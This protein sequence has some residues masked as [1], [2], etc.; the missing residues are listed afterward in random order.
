MKI[1]IAMLLT[2]C[3]VLVSSLSSC[4]NSNNNSEAK[5]TKIG[6]VLPLSGS[7]SAL[8]KDLQQ[9]ANLAL[10][11]VNNTQ[12]KQLQF[13]LED[14]GSTP[15]GATVAFNKLI[16]Q[17]ISSI[18]GPVTSSESKATFPLAQQYQVVAFSPL[19]AAQGLSEIGD[20]V[21]QGNLTVDVVIPGG[22]ELTATKLNYK[23]VAILVDSADLFSQSAFD[24]LEQTFITKGIDIVA[25]ETLQTN[26]SDFSTQLTRIKDTSPDAI[27]ISALPIEVVKILTQAKTLGIPENVTFI[28]PLAFSTEEVAQAGTAAENVITFST[29]TSSAQTTGNQAFI[30]KYRASFGTEPSRFLAQE[31]AAVHILAEAVKNAESTEAASIRDALT[32]IKDFDTILGKF[33]FDSSGRAIYDPIILVVKNGAFEAF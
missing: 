4:N 1:K 28:I 11:E 23:K 22:I 19:A 26:D 20:F 32:N 9:V 10:E 3:I 25:T 13:V 2:L 14:S 27:F 16:N 31:Y 12:T 21:F 7:L 33:S 29:W 8:G 15:E 6:L 17:Q 5:V 24:V 18:L 30:E